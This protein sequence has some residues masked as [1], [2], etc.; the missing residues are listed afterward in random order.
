MPQLARKPHTR[1][2]ERIVLWKLQLGR[3]DAAFEGCAFGPLDQR[4]PDEHVVFVDWACGYSFRGV[5]G[6]VFVFL[7]EAF[8]GYC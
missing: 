2:R 3:E 7:E 5:V 8:G 1:R 6:E 4:F